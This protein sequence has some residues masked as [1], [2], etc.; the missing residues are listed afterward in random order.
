MGRLRL[1]VAVALIVASSMAALGTGAASVGAAANRWPH[2]VVNGFS[3]PSGAG[4]WTLFSDGTVSANGAPAYGDASGVNLN[5]PVVGGA[6]IPSGKGYWLVARD[7]GIFS[8]GA[9]RFYGSMGGTYLN[10]PV[11]SMAPTSDG[12]GYWLV[13]R[14]GGIFSFGNAKFYGSTGGLELAQPIN[15]ITTS[16]TGHGYRMVARDGGIFSFGDAPFYGSLPSKGLQVNDVAGMAPTSSGHGYWIARSGGE[17]YSFGD[18]KPFN[19]YIASMCDPVTAIFSNPSAQGFRLITR[20]GATIPF[21]KAPGGSLP[22]GS[23]VP[24]PPGTRTPA[25]ISRHAFDLIEVGM[26]YNEVLSFI[27]GSGVLWEDYKYAGYD[28]VFYMWNGPGGSSALLE[29]QN[30][31]L[32]S[33]VQQG[34]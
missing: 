29:F 26:S 10:R 8:Y 30:N 18:A 2:T 28:D 27:G 4:F 11:F 13:A 3:T 17:I 31:R 20:S 23:A 1:P 32:V 33:K 5:G 34:L 22:T 25:T 9:A 7:G 12:K 21:G 19:D 14:D 6:V 16:T 15:G 24:C